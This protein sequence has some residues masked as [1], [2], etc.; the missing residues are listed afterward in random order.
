MGAIRTLN[1]ASRTVRVSFARKAGHAALQRRRIGQSCAVGGF[2][3]AD[4]LEDLEGREVFAFSTTTRSR[5]AAQERRQCGGE[6]AAALC[7]DGPAPG[8]EWREREFDAEDQDAVQTLPVD[9][10]LLKV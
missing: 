5:T 4:E 3:C 6:L 7:R 2:F 9:P 10:R 8:T 1:R